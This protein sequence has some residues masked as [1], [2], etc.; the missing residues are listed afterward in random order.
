MGSKKKPIL[1]DEFWYLPKEEAIYLLSPH[2]ELWKL[3]ANN[4]IILQNFCSWFDGKLEDAGFVYI[5]DV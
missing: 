1:Q 5:G 2:L 3:T 4:D